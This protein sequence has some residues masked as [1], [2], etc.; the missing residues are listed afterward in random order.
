MLNIFL[1]AKPIIGMVN[2]KPLPGFPGFPGMQMV[3]EAA[4]YDATA[5]EAGSV[6]GILVENTFSYPHSMEIGPELVA[7]MG[8]ITH[9]IVK[10]VKVPVGVVVVME[11]G[12]N[13]AI[14]IAVSSGAQFVRAFSYNE[15]MVSSFGIYQG[16]PARLIRYRQ[17][18]KA[19]NIAIFGDVHLKN[20][21]PL[22]PRTLEQSVL[23]AVHTGVDALIVTGIAT[24]SA[25]PVEI[26]MRAKKVAGSTPVLLGS[27]VAP[28]N[29]RELLQEADGAIIGSYFKTRV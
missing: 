20:S 7:S 17:F 26:A 4:L 29:A 16:N 6:D 18:L 28:D 3:L 11:P 10:A 1:K 22:G 12:D 15:A 19:E 27:G 2:L 8:I 13:S 5:L 23:D 14:G 9:E 24:G 25:P 21:I